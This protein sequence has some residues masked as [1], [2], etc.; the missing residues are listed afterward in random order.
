[1]TAAAVGAVIAL[2]AQ[3]AAAPAQP[4]WPT[5]RTAEAS[6]RVFY[7]ANSDKNGLDLSIPATD[8]RPAYT[9]RCHTF[10]Y[11]TRH[12]SYS[13]MMQC[14]MF[15]VPWV[16]GAKNLLDEPSVSS[17]TE[18]RAR[19]LPRHLAPRCAVT[20]EWGAVRHFWFRNLVVTL[21]VTDIKRS[22]DPERPD[23]P[24]IEAYTF[25]VKVEPYPDA[26]APVAQRIAEKQPEWF[27]DGECPL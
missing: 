20:P 26:P 5:V 14:Y 4:A 18:S 6:V 22:P 21:A 24:F 9:L 8:G 10:D 3:A 25:K 16:A 11:Q 27:L 13:G 19:F 23:R 15:P 2:L 7:I 1:M 12:L 17:S